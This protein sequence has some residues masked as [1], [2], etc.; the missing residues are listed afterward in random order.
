MFFFSLLHFSQCAT[1]N[2]IRI[3][4]KYLIFVLFIVFVFQLFVGAS[5]MCAPVRN[6]LPAFATFVFLSS[7]EV[8]WVIVL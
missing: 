1:R 3:N 5:C 6:Y 7:S 2:T 8:S 4:L